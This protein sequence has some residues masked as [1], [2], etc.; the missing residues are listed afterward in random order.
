MSKKKIE[1]YWPPELRESPPFRAV[2]G[3]EQ[4]EVYALWDSIAFLYDE[5]FIESA[6]GPAL[7]RWEK[8]L[9][10]P[11]KAGGLPA[12][13]AAVL[14]RLKETPPF[15]MAAL[16][17]ALAEM[18][19]EGRYTARLSAPYVLRVA[20]RPG[21]AETEEVLGML[22][23]T[24]PAN[25]ECGVEIWFVS[26]SGLRGKRHRELAAFTHEGIR[27]MME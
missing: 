26:H 1:E 22:R 18:C 4:A 19:G 11:P 23:R 3:A 17:A 12:R 5:Q 2:A 20:V 7:A 25:I 24:V 21:R 16:E 27:R 10:I 8:M 9:G 14:A 6:S 15:N 13:R